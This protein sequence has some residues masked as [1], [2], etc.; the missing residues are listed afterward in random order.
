MY[1]CK[2]A[3][4]FWFPWLSKWMRRWWNLD[5][6]IYGVQFSRLSQWEF[7]CGW[8]K[9]CIAKSLSISKRY[10]H[11][12]WQCPSLNLCNRMACETLTDNSLN[13]IGYSDCVKSSQ[14]KH[15][16][17]ARITYG[18]GSSSCFETN[19]R[20]VEIANTKIKHWITVLLSVQFTNG[21]QIINNEIHESRDH[22]TFRIT[23]LYVRLQ[24]AHTQSRNELMH[25]PRKKIQHNLHC[26]KQYVC[27]VN[28]LPKSGLMQMLI[29][30]NKFRADRKKQKKLPQK[31][32]LP[33]RCSLCVT[34]SIL[35]H[36][37][38]LLGAKITFRRSFFLGS[39][40]FCPWSN[41]SESIATRD[42]NKFSNWSIARD[43][44]RY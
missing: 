7:R 22:T 28:L 39:V 35:K 17:M 24:H 42:H 15:K 6:I 5:D 30:R 38:L 31:I 19:R 34:F 25:T 1:A 3:S 29:A 18:I 12:K 37:I 16:T 8:V 33:G 4:K 27:C 9:M 26:G 36:I 40:F 44:G 32:N 10:V 43:N 20:H 13:G 14:D 2:K 23:V 41:V 21:T 11:L